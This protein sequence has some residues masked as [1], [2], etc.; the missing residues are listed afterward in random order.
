MVTIETI[1]INLFK[2]FNV[3]IV[4]LNN[5][6]DEVNME[7]E[8]TEDLISIIHHFSM[9]MYSNRRKKLKEIQKELENNQ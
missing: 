9:K 2:K 3:E 5:P 7:Q 1:R 6:I 8:L 4:V